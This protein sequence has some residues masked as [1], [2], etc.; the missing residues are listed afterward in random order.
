MM[1][2]MSKEKRPIRIYMDSGW[3]EDNFEVNRAMFDLLQR[4]GCE[5]NLDVMY[6]ASGVAHSEG[7][8]ATRIHIPFQ[9]LF[10]RYAQNDMRRLRVGL[11]P[12]RDPQS[13]SI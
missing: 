3:P 8:W 11:Q 6:L 9:F 7:D 12:A 5:V 10:V 2:I 4:Q 1:R 13:V